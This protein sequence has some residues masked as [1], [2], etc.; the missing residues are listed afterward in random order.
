MNSDRFVK[1]WA[2]VVSVALF[3]AFAVTGCSRLNDGKVRGGSAIDALM[4][5]AESIMNSDAELADSL[6]NLIDPEFIRG[7]ERKARYALLYTEAEFKNYQPF[8]TDSLILTAAR[9]YSISNNLDYRFLS[10]YYLGCAYM[11]LKQFTDAAVALAQAEMLVNTIDNDYWIGLLYTQLGDLFN[12]SYDYHRAEEYFSKSADYYEK[13]GKEAHHIYALYDIARCRNDLHDYHSGDSLLKVVEK[14][15]IQNDDT[16]L[17]SSILYDRLF[18]SLFLKDSDFSSKVFKDNISKAQYIYERI[19][20]LELMALY[21]NSIKDF[22]QS[23]SYLQE[24]W[25][26]KLSARDSIYLSYVSFLVADSRG[27]ADKS[28][29]YYRNYISLQN[30]NLRKVL[31]QPILGVQKEH[32][33]VFAENEQLKN[34]HARTTLVLCVL[35]FMLIIVIVMVTYHYKKKHMQEQLYDSLAVVEELSAINHINTD[36]IEHLKNEVRRQFRERH[37]M[38]NRLYSMY[39]DSESQDKITKQQLKVTINGLI[40]DYTAPENVKKL[41]GLIDESYDGIMTRLSAQDFGLTEKELQL[42]RFSFA[43]LSS[44]SVSV[45][46]NE[47]PQNIY[48]LKSRLLKKVKRNSEEL[49]ETLN[50]IW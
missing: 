46:I 28:L 1:I 24:A 48:Q 50:N 27:Q 33:R 36:K 18:C 14:W 15:A 44:K 13:A 37:D 2:A 20:Y 30:E 5:K 42:L 47:T 10:Y 43:G 31:N 40:K 29:E 16:D 26:C 17:C 19:N 41:D 45:I 35:I 11:E 49:W 4:Y 39:F 21:H 25:N 12:E 23:D 6:M 38:S 3:A 9:Y 7:K 34:R 8:T 22:A 32:Y